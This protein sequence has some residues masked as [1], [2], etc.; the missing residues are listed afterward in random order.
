M[1]RSPATFTPYQKGT[2]EP[3]DKDGEHRLPAHVGAKEQCTGYHQEAPVVESAVWRDQQRPKRRNRHRRR[4]AGARPGER[5]HSQAQ[6]QQLKDHKR[7]RS[8][9]HTEKDPLPGVLPCLLVRQ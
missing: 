7:M 9:V 2:V 6:Q 3:T 1:P 5:H 8:R 4:A